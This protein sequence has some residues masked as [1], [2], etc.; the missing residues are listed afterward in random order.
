MMTCLN[1]LI[2][3]PGLA[4]AGLCVLGCSRPRP[5]SRS[6]EAKLELLLVAN[7][8][9]LVALPGSPTRA[10]SAGC[11]HTQTPGE[12]GLVTARVHSHLRPPRRRRGLHAIQ[13][14]GRSAYPDPKGGGWLVGWGPYKE[15]LRTMKFSGLGKS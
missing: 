11:V 15:I 8:E 14:A 12:E 2:G 7:L 9:C 4:P 6:A 13:G 3:E 1:A 10:P 5:M